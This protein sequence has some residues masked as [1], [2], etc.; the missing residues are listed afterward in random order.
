[1]L[2]Q[3]GLS[4]EDQQVGD[5]MQ[6]SGNCRASARFCVM[7]LLLFQSSGP[8]A[9]PV[10]PTLTGKEKLAGKATDEQRVNNCKVPLAK[11]GEKARPDA[12]IAKETNK[13]EGS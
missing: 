9:E 13:P 1:M 8:Q 6:R 2:L 7:V 12:C 5:R 4:V 11:R 3:F 10:N